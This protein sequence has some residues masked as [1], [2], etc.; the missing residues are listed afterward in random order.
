MTTTAKKKYRVIKDIFPMYHLSTDGIAEAVQ[1][2]V[3][4]RARAA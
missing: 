2:L 4:G 1:A 3:G